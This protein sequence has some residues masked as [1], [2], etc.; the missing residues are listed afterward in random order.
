MGT[1]LAAWIVKHVQTTMKNIKFY[2]LKYLN[3]LTNNTSLD[4][5]QYGKVETI[6]TW[7]FSGNARPAQNGGF[8][9]TT[10]TTDTQLRETH[11][12][13]CDISLQVLLNK[14]NNG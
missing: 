6:W 8:D 4:Q 1:F 2:T 14:L 12:T 9:T 10:T 7:H 5:R 11:P 13:S 3:W